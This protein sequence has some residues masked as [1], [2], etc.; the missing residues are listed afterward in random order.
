VENYIFI[1]TENTIIKKINLLNFKVLC[2]IIEMLTY[3]SKA[4]K[5]E[6]K[7]GGHCGNNI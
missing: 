5:K 1:N 2:N 6:I 4:T 7:K 3:T